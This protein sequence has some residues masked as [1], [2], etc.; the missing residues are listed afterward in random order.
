MLLQKMTA[1]AQHLIAQNLFAVENFDYWME[2]GVS[3]YCCNKQGKGFVVGR[4]A[5]DAVLS[6]ERFS[7][8]ASLFLALINIWINENDTGREQDNLELPQVDVTPLDD[9]TADVEVRIRFLQD[10]SIM[11]SDQGAIVMNGVRYGIAQLQNADANK[12]GVGDTQ[13]RPTDL[14]YER[15]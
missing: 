11:P 2:N 10:I 13:E 9:S 6:V 7:S 12:V 1:L 5:Y 14:P 15:D 4:F 3:E 8:D